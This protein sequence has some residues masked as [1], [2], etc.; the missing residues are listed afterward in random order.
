MLRDTLAVMCY[1]RR[2]LTRCLLSLC[3]LICHSIGLLAAEPQRAHRSRLGTG[4]NGLVYWSTELPF[5]DV[6]KMS[7]PWMSGTAENWDDKRALDLDGRGWVRSLQPGQRAVTLLMWGKQMWVDGVHRAPTGRYIVEYDGEGEI[8]LAGAS[9]VESRRGRQVLELTPEPPEGGLALM[10]TATD[11]KNYIRNIRVLLPG[12]VSGRTF[13]PAFL[14]SLRGYDVIRFLG[15][16]HG[17]S[18]EDTAHVPHDWASRPVVEDARWESSRRGPPLEVMLALQNELRVDGWH[19]IPHLASDDFV[20]RYAELIRSKLGPGLKIHVEH[21]NE[22]WN[23][24]FAQH[25]YAERRGLEL[26]LSED[27]FT[28]GNRYHARRTREIGAIFREVLGRQRVVVVLAGQADTPEIAE[29]MLGWEGTAVEVDALATAPYFGYELGTPAKAA[30]VEKMTL[31]DLFRELE[32]KTLPDTLGYVARHA[33]LARRFELPLV[34]YEAGQHLVSLEQQETPHAT[35]LFDAANRDPRMGKLYSRLLT[36]W[37]RLSKG[38]LFIHLMHCGETG[39]AGRWGLIEYLGQPREKSP[40]Y[41]AV[42]RW[43]E[44]VR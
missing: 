44:S 7:S 26:G 6:F 23:P 5:N 11:P 40:K 17:P 25:A 3:L 8:E 22:V 37:D 34:S 13:N 31:D 16:T 10:I 20:R 12:T 35:A 39:T 27:P 21:S 43:K 30:V 19:S 41:D 36:E 4:L 14:A 2:V 42:R 15:W 1:V 18:A 32:T 38:G 9:V 28:A 33:E 24:T 29:Q